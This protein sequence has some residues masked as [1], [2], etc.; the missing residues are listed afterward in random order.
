MSIPIRIRRANSEDLP[1]LINLLNILFSIEADFTPNPQKQRQGLQLM[2]EEEHRCILVAEIEGNIAGMVTAQLVVSTAEGA[3]SGWIEDMV[4]FPEY[5]QQ[6]VGSRLLQAIETWCYQND[7]VRVQL[8]VDRENRPALEF[9][10]KNGW[11]GTQLIALRKLL[12]EC[13]RD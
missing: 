1:V 12:S 13:K 10:S 4:I 11:H 8:L 5:R 6:G 7:A 3:Y 2:L 9:Y